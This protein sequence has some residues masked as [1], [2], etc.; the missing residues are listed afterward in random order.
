MDGMFLLRQACVTSR[1]HNCFD[2]LTFLQNILALPPHLKGFGEAMFQA[3]ERLVV[4]DNQQTP[5]IQ[6]HAPHIHTVDRPTHVANVTFTKFLKFFETFIRGSGNEQFLFLFNM[7]QQK[8]EIGE[9]EIR[10]VLLHL[11][12]LAD[13]NQKSQTP[14]YDCT[15]AK[16]SGKSYE[17]FVSAVIS[18]LNTK[19]K[20]PMDSEDFYD[21]AGNVI[22]STPKAISY[23]LWEKFLRDP[24]TERVRF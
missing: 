13:Y 15:Q 21:W 6:R 20:L 10:Q 5:E 4:L 1:K 11:A 9:A 17:P 7:Y 22:P 24:E 8:A 16:F 23:F 19:K 18:A 3:T 14:G 12:A 2:L